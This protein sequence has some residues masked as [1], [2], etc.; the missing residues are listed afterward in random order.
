M[1]PPRN[2][3]FAPSRDAIGRDLDIARAK[4][5][6]FGNNPNVSDDR[7]LRRQ[8]QA[9]KEAA[10][11]GQ[12]TRPVLT[13][14]GSTVS[15]L[16]QMTQDAPR[17]LAAERERL[18]N[19][20]GQTP[21]ELAGDFARGLGSIV[22]GVSDRVMSGSFGLLGIAKD[23]YNK[24]SG[25][26]RSGVDKL[27]NV[28]LEILKNKDK[29]NFVSNKPKLQGIEQLEVDAKLAANIERNAGIIAANRNL[30]GD[31]SE[32]GG[33]AL[34]GEVDMQPMSSLL[35]QTQYEMPQ[36]PPGFKVASPEQREFLKEIREADKMYEGI[37]S[38]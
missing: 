25:A 6:F 7:A 26:L 33:P 34:P 2:V 29:Y 19:I 28:D 14:S 30:F 21:T 3:R 36:R 11:K 20:Y 23:L 32:F 16:V 37:I 27:S 1:A 31:Y 13:D 17:S 12:F 35:P 8:T 4:K 9:D 15:G 38:S 22:G 24:A 18:D 10:F 5:E